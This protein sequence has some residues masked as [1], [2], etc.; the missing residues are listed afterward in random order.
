MSNIKEWKYCVVGNITKSHID[1]NGVVRY[2]T[3]AFTGGTK[4]Y[5]CGKYWDSSRETITVIG[6]TRGK[7]YHVID[8]VPTHIENVRCSKAYHPAVLNLMNNWEMYDLWWGN[9]AEDKKE[10]VE[11]THKWHA[12]F[13]ESPIPVLLRL[14]NQRKGVILLDGYSGCG[15]TFLLKQLKLKSARPVYLFSYENVV[16][17]IIRAAKNDEDS[18]SYLLKLCEEN[19]I[20]GIEDVDYLRGKEA[21]QACLVAM[22]QTAAKKHLVILTGNNV[23]TRTPALAS[24]CNEDIIIYPNRED[25]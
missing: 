18:E 22:V 15:K 10:A 1:K 11:F 23:Q 16:D 2:G 4:V 9:S 5:L 21:T 12:E 14:I 20:I 7:K 25:S 24:L 8:T 19:C 3:P 17:E 13:S 6:M